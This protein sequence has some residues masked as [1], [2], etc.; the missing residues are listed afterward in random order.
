MG[1]NVIRTFHAIGQGAFYSER[2]NNFNIVYDCGA[3]PLTKYAKSVV[4]SAFSKT[5]IIDVLF[6]SH[7]DYDHISAISTLKQ[8]VGKIKRVI[9]PLLHYEQKNLLINI[10]RALSQ[11]VLKLIDDPEAYFGLD[12]DIIYIKA[13][14]ERSIGDFFDSEAPK[15]N[16]QDISNFKNNNSGRI[17]IESGRHLFIDKNSNWFFVPYNYRNETRS[18]QLITD[19][20]NLGFDVSKL[21]NDSKYSLTQITTAAS[22]KALR[23][24]YSRIDGN[25]NENSM[26]LYSGPE[27]KSNDDTCYICSDFTWP[28]YMFEAGCIYTGDSDLNK[29]NLGLIYS[30]FVLNVGTV[31]IP[32]HGSRHSFSIDSLKSFWP[33]V[34]CPISYGTKNTYGHPA[35]E[36]INKL[37]KNGFM[38]LHINEDPKSEFSQII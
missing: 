35:V 25:V 22:R 4:Q 3:M 9:L 21:K 2:H 29:V 31:Q 26:L 12:T 10:N 15:I 13:T 36:V 14:D 11:H 19:L 33:F 20:N 24:A 23:R 30:N 18:K 17:E 34:I 38:P 7:F 1:Y 28:K 37:T 32:H 8:S 16:L 6:I 27:K 5:D